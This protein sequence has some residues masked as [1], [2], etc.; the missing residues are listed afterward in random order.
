MALS[1]VLVVEGHV[2]QAHADMRTCSGRYETPLA[3]SLS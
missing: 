2:E 1:Y 3:S